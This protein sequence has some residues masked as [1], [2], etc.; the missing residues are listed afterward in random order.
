MARVPGSKGRGTFCLVM[1]VSMT[2]PLDRQVAEEVARRASARLT[3]LRSELPDL[4]ARRFASADPEILSELLE[5]T[6]LPIGLADREPLRR[7]IGVEGVDYCTNRLVLNRLSPRDRPTLPSQPATD[8]TA[9]DDD[10]LLAA[11]RFVPETLP[12]NVLG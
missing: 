10:D 5:L 6:R 11:R 8:L 1:G 2:D 3:I 12:G 9:L 4:L 7:H